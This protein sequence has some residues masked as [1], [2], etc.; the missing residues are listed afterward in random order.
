M[1]TEVK[2]VQ[3]RSLGSDIALVLGWSLL[4]GMC[5]KIAV[6]LPFTPIPIQ[7][8]SILIFL[9]A[10]LFGSK[11]ATLATL[12][13]I[14]QGIAGLPV[15]AGG[16]GGLAVFLGPRGGYMVGYVVAAFLIGFILEQCKERSLKNTALALAAGNGA[17]FFCGA[18]YLATFVGWS[19]AILL[20]VV[21]FV[22]GDLLKLGV[23][24]KA[25]QWMKGMG[26][27]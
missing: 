14:A 1:H 16:A 7:T 11:R 6:P 19:Q 15:F 27:N 2:T 18:A 23:I 4:L 8:Q 10:V 5:S 3:E 24:L 25:L 9:G 13:F 22:L 17:L 20:G 26:K 21:P 12:A